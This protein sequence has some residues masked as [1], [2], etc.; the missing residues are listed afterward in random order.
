MTQ[1]GCSTF[2]TVPVEGRFAYSAA[3]R[4]RSVSVK[5]VVGH[6]EAGQGNHDSDNR[7]RGKY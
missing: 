2:H 6:G 5:W 4:V 7:G 1:M 3:Y